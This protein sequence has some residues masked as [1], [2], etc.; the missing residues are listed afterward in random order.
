MGD[1]PDLLYPLTLGGETCGVPEMAGC[2]VEDPSEEVLATV[3]CSELLDPDSSGPEEAI[4]SLVAFCYVVVIP[5]KS[6]TRVQLGK[7]A[8]ERQTGELG[9]EVE[10]Q[11]R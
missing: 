10:S 1:N 9:A 7:D 5:G 11:E 6:S 2:V 3:C 4:S 8:F